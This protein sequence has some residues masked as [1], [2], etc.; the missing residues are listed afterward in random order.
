MFDYR[1]LSY[2]RTKTDE[3][4]IRTGYANHHVRIRSLACKPRP[5]IPI[6]FESILKL[7]KTAV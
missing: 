5:Y 4:S 3:T 7:K 1:V 6:H 2:A